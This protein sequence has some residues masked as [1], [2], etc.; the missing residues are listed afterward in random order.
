[1][2]IRMAACKIIGH[3]DDLLDPT[4]HHDYGPNGLQVPESDQIQTVVTGAWASAT[5][6]S[7]RRPDLIPGTWPF[8]RTGR[9][10]RHIK[11]RLSE[12][13]AIRSARC[14]QAGGSQ[15]RWPYT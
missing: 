4:A 3:L 8:V 1:M 11:L 12:T 5:S 2:A 10:F 13:R 6:T 7:T 15:L 9:P 14:K